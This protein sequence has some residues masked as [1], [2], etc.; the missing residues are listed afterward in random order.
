MP[1]KMKIETRTLKRV[2]NEERK[3]WISVASIEAGV[4]I[5][6][7]SLLLGGM[8][9]EA[10]PIKSAIMAGTLGY[11]L[12]VLLTAVMGVQG[13][14]LGSPLC[15]ISLSSFGKKG[16]KYL[17]TLLL[18]ISLMGWFAVQAYVC[19]FAFTG[20]IN[21]FLHINC[22]IWV[23]VLVWGIIML[24]TAVYGIDALK[25]LNFAAVPA[26]VLVTMFG[27]YLAVSRYGLGQLDAPV[28]DTMTMMQGVGLTFSFNAT[29]MVIAP[30]Y[31]RYNKSR[32]DAAKSMILGI[33]PAGLLMFIMGAI[34]SKLTG[35]YD[36][37]LILCELGIP[38]LG[39]IV[40]ILATWTSNTTN[41]YSA[42]I[43][44]VMLFSL[45]DNKRAV[46]TLI[47]GVVGTI[48]ALAGLAS[49]FELVLNILGYAFAPMAGVMIAEYWFVLRG[50]PEKWRVVPGINRAGLVSWC[51]GVAATLAIPAGLPVLNG[52]LVSG[53]A[54]VILHP[55]FYGKPVGIQKEGRS[56]EEHNL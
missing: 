21:E 22:P 31:T 20:M 40:L 4:M 15:V 26:L 46:T 24:V 29:G 48:L 45:K 37:S 6:V 14:D 19:G 52:L 35:L 18:V 51:G 44:M 42:G 7:P 5:C 49:C 16:G 53:I 36:I 55:V 9:A 28:A 56:G 27:C 25:W 33:L 47:A 54:F 17:A 8:L 3:S 32:N 13:Y 30:D 34:M 10:M 11:V 43:S 39:L 41:A 12:A 1:K 50:D 23:S 2:T 38:F